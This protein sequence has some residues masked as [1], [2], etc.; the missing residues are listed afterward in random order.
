MFRL[1]A[2]HVILMIMATAALTASSYAAIPQ[3]INFQGKLTDEAD[4]PVEDGEYTVMFSIW[5]MEAEGSQLWAGEY[6]ATLHNGLFTVVLGPIPSEVF[7]VA[8][9]WLSVELEGMGEM[10]PRTQLISTPYTYHAL[11]ADSAYSFA[12]AVDCGWIRDNHRIRLKYASD[13]VAIGPSTPTAKLDVAGDIRAR[14]SLITKDIRIGSLTEDG[15]LRIRGDDTGGDAI[16]LKEFSGFGGGSLSIFESNGSTYAHSLDID[17]DAGGGGYMAIGGG[18]TYALVVDGNYNNSNNPYVGII[19]ADRSALFNMDESGNNA[20]DLP[21]GSISS[22]EIWNEAGVANSARTSAVNLGTS[23]TT[24][25]SRLMFFPSS[26]YVVVIGSAAYNFWHANGTHDF[27]RFGISDTE[28]VIPSDQDHFTNYPAEWGTF[29]FSGNMTVHDHYSVSAG[30]H[31]FYLL[32]THTG[33]YSPYSAAVNDANL[34][35]MFF[36]TAYGAFSKT[37]SENP[38]AEQ[39]VLD[40]MIMDRVEAENEALRQELDEKL[41]AL[42]AEMR[43]QQAADTGASDRQTNQE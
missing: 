8:T 17:V 15:S 40:R 1:G 25:L 36:P 18:N 3:Y 10:G 42:R 20:V 37:G 11:V 13:S 28:G 5:D 9:R 29:N 4:V 33:N 41:A 34:T 35:V 43:K 27:V 22:F 16:R 19:G 12:G 6:V 23:P 32:G 24:V 31:T 21:E 14:D 38:N 26:G 39:D 30:Y 2:R 7:N